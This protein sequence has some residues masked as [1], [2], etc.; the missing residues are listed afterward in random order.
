MHHLVWML[1]FSQFKPHALNT[2]VRKKPQNSHWANITETSRW[3]EIRVFLIPYLNTVSRECLNGIPAETWMWQLHLYWRLQP[4]RGRGGVLSGSAKHLHALHRVWQRKLVCSFRCGWGGER[5]CTYHGGWCHS[6]A[7]LDP[8][9]P[10]PLGC[11]SRQFPSAK[12]Q[13]HWGN[14]KHNPDIW[15]RTLTHE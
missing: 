13:T 8:G 11:L 5:D 9:E 3:G 14:T 2:L 7:A 12:T 4:G 6:P 1:S 15:T 10:L